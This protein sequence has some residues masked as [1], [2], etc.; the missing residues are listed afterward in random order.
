MTPMQTSCELHGSVVVA[1][2]AVRMMQPAVHEII[3][4]IAMRNGFMSAI[5]PMLVCAVRLGCAAHRILLIDRQCMFVDVI[6]VHVM[7]MTIVKIVHMTVMPDRG[8]A[9]VRA[10]LMGVIGVVLL[11]AGSHDVTPS[12]IF[13]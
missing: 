10:M 11:V 7:Q 9:A 8:V 2:V 5:W 13:V 4:M 6:L 3:D 12:L 1:V